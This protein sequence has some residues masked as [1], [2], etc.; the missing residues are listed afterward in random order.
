MTIPNPKGL[1]MQD[2]KQEGA[3]WRPTSALTSF[4]ALPLLFAA[5]AFL[6]GCG[7]D[8]QANPSPTHAL[9]AIA[10]NTP[11]PVIVAAGDIV[12]NQSET[13]NSTSKGT[14]QM[15]ATSNL[16]MEQN[17]ATV[18]PLGD[19]QYPTG[20]LSDFNTSYAPT[21]GRVKNISRPV[22]G[23]HEYGTSGA[24]GYF[25]YF[26]TAAGNP[27]KGYY[28]Y[29]VGRWHLIAL[30]SNC[31]EVGG[32]ETGSPQE[33]W[34]KADLTAHPTKCTLA[35]WHHPRFS[36]AL[37]G[38]NPTY[39]A[40]WQDLYAARAEIVLSAHDHSYER[41]APQTPSAST[42]S[43]QGI[44]EFVVGTGGKSLYP[45]VTVQPNSEVRNNETY[46]VLKLTLNPES[47]SWQ[48]VPVKGK[49]FT[50]SGSGV[51]H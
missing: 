33:Q 17:F 10:A 7:R 35:Y 39:D 36:S 24:T 28:S 34:L 22:V 13:R 20:A 43:Q 25:N 11:A 41:F 45:F 40:F 50:D 32:C 46:G 29:D 21:W 42:N 51:C 2:D 9:R 31:Q 5:S 48:F 6:N 19:L 18:L 8:I 49:T 44:R 27:N 30:N 26:G 16:L 15:Q 47:Y 3:S 38:N 23:N 37:H 4:L 12:C 1:L 14:C